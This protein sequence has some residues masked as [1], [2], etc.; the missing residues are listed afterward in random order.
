MHDLSRQERGLNDS[1]GTDQ[2][3]AGAGDAD[4]EYAAPGK[5]RHGVSDSG[6]WNGAAAARILWQIKRR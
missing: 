2:G 6:A 4:G 5:S 1:I 3:A